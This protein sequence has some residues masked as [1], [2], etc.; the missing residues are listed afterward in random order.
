[1][2]YT[3]SIDFCEG[4][5][6]FLNENGIE[7]SVRKEKKHRE[8]YFTS[9][10]NCKKFL[11]NI[12]QETSLYLKRKYDLAMTFLNSRD[13]TKETLREK[14]EKLIKDSSV[15]IKRYLNGES[16]PQIAKDYNCGL[17][18]ILRILKENNIP[19]HKEKNKNN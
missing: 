10:K 18:P 14:R 3:G 11:E 9:L 4:F 1:M 13:F 2:S 15:I 19:L 12:Y 8:L 17:P 6:K 7:V 5:K 16:T